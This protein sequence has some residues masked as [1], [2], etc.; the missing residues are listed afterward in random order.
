MATVLD[1]LHQDHINM[2]LLLDLLEQQLEHANLLHCAH[3]LRRL[4]VIETRYTPPE[5]RKIYKTVDVIQL[6]PREQWPDAAREKYAV[7]NGRTK[8]ALALIEWL[9][10]KPTRANATR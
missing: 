5:I 10:E 3:S 1:K 9:A 8:G 4:G 6:R 2:A 7:E